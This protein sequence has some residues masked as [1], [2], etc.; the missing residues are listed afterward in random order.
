MMEKRVAF[1]EAM[2]TKSPKTGKELGL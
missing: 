2:D 1:T